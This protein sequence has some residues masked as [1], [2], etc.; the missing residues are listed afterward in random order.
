MSHTPNAE[1][2]KVLRGLK[3]GK[4]LK[5]YANTKDMLKDFGD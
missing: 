1:T 5:T 3:Q 2:T 4:T